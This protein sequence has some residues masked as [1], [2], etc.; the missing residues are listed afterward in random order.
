MMLDLEVDEFAHDVKTLKL[1]RPNMNTLTKRDIMRLQRLHKAF[2][3]KYEEEMRRGLVGGMG[4]RP[5]QY[6]ALKERDSAHRIYR[7]ARMKYKQS[8]KVR[9]II[10]ISLY[11]HH[12]IIISPYHHITIPPYHHTTIS[13]YYHTTIPPYHHTTISRT[14]SY[15]HINIPSYHPTPYHHQRHHTT[16]N[17][18][19]NI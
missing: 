5:S 13:T 14:P 11:H 17:Q 19:Q 1:F 15:H 3:E 18:K 16:I 12:H 2:E 6:L 8:L 9:T 10:I 7:T 4:L